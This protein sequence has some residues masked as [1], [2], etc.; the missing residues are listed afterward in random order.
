MLLL[1]KISMLFFGALFFFNIL[2]IAGL[3]PSKIRSRFNIQRKRSSENQSQK[4]LN[5]KFLYRY[6][7]L[8][9]SALNSYHP[10]HFA[11]FFFY[12]F[13]GFLV[14]SI[15]LIIGTGSWFFSVLAS[16]FFFILFPVVLLK[17]RHI[18]L[19]NKL[20]A[21][22]YGVVVN[23]I[24][25]YKKRDKIM[26]H[27]LKAVR[28]SKSG[29]MNKVLSRLWINIQGDDQEKE[30]AAKFFSYAIGDWGPLLSHAILL[31]AKEGFDV[32][33]TLSTIH[34]NMKDFQKEVSEAESSNRE[35]VLLGYLPLPLS[36]ILV[37]LFAWFIPTD[38]S[39]FQYTFGTEK[40]LTVFVI[41]MITGVINVILAL[42]FKSPKRGV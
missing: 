7:L 20:Q 32:E 37:C 27:A 36:L 28:D 4:L 24:Q 10:K 3:S 15:V 30:E 17:V 9:S 26:V 19:R 34:E 25:E 41:S 40:G 13:F 14:V 29:H 23:L 8:L 42:V 39:G 16:L 6:H 1:L 35:V 5:Y 11:F 18:Y 21:E 38:G 2:L 12:Q 31:G 22:L 33:D